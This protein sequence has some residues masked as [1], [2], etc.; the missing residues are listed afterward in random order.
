M[1]AVDR[2][3]VVIHWRQTKI[4]RNYPKDVHNESTHQAHDTMHP[5]WNR[6]CK[7]PGPGNYGSIGTTKKTV[8]TL[9]GHIFL[10]YVRLDTYPFIVGW[11]LGHFELG[12]YSR[13]EEK[14]ERDDLFEEHGGHKEKGNKPMNDSIEG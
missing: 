3:I 6:S 7:H 4:L 10:T 8:R 2:R 13:D 5:I 11:T 12:P 9:R 14:N 1:A